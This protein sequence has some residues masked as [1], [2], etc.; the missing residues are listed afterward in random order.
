MVTEQVFN[1]TRHI[2]VKKI[3]TQKNELFQSIQMVYTF[4]MK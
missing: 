3:G 1:G 4:F 2:H